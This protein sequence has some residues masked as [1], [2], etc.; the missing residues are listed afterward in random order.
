MSSLVLGLML[1]FREC[2]PAVVDTAKRAQNLGS[3]LVRELGSVMRWL[4]LLLL[5]LLR[6][7]TKD[8]GR[9]R[10]P[11]STIELQHSKAYTYDEVQ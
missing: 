3:P 9:D 2:P 10:I 5:W 7:S 4:H 1:G 8:Y 11:S 6:E